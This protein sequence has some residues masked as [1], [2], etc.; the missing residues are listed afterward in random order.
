[1]TVAAMDRSVHQM[2]GIGKIGCPKGRACGQDGGRVR[3]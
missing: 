3:E 2:A 1:L